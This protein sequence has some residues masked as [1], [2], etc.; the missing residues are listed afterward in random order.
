MKRLDLGKDSINKLLFSF[1]LPC[2]ISMIINSIY[3][4]IDQ[5]FIGRVLVL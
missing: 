5:I 1:S 4:I 2:V 3:N